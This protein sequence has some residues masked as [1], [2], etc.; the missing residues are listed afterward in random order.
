MTQNKIVE[1]F[2]LRTNVEREKALIKHLDYLGW[3]R[4][5]SLFIRN[6][7][8][9]GLEVV[10][11]TIAEIAQEYNIAPDDDEKL[12]SKVIN[13]CDVNLAGIVETFLLARIALK[14]SPK[15]PKKASGIATTRPTATKQRAAS[16]P[17]ATQKEAE[18]ST[19]VSGDDEADAGNEED[20]REKLRGL[21]GAT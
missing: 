10:N 9:K 1:D 17:P 5:R 18:V 12:L 14:T 20:W 13:H 21:S 11:N 7:L 8:L 15:P 3:G 2:I 19:E 4:T 6:C 16:P